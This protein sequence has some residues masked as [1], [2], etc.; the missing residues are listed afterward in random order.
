MGKVLIIKSFLI[1]GSNGEELDDEIVETT[2]HLT[3]ND[4]ELSLIL[5]GYHKI[6]ENNYDKKLNSTLY[7][8]ATIIIT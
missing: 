5:E 8:L 4:A 6:D 7:K 1:R 2:R 3:V